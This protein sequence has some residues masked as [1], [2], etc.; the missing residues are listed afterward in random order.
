MGW[1]VE[2][3]NP[4]GGE[5]FRICPDWPWGPPSLLYNGYPVSFLGVKWPVHGI[6][7]WLLSSAEVKHEYSYTSTPPLCQSWRVTGQPL[8]DC[9]VWWLTVGILLL[10]QHNGLNHFRITL[11]NNCCV[12]LLQSSLL[13]FNYW[14]G[15]AVEW[16]A[17]STLCTLISADINGCHPWSGLWYIAQN[18][19][20]VI[21]VL[22]RV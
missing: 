3:L 19:I 7:R 22:V 16:V 18:C 12:L 21:V 9:C 10:L 13:I 14:T 6:D 5:I 11:K 1:K 2:G 8:P 15:M 20:T 17:L 4:G